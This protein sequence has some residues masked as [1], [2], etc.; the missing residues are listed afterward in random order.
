MNTVAQQ[1]KAALL[2][3]KKHLVKY[4]TYKSSN[5]ARFASFWENL[6]SINHHLDKT[7]AYDDYVIREES[8]TAT[9]DSRRSSNADPTLAGGGLAALESM[10]EENLG[11]LFATK[12][13]VSEIKTGVGS[14]ASTAQ[15]RASSTSSRQRRRRNRTASIGG[16]SRTN[17]V[18]F[19]GDD[20]FN[21]GSLRE[22]Y[23]EDD[24]L[25]D[26]EDEYE[27]EDSDSE[28]GT[29]FQSSNQR[30]L[31]LMI[32]KMKALGMYS[33]EKFKYTYGM[34]SPRS[35]KKA[36][37]AAALAAKGNVVEDVS[38][39]LFNV[40]DQGKYVD[41]N[42]SPLSRWLNTHPPEAAR[43]SALVIEGSEGHLEGQNTPR[44]SWQQRHL[45]PHPYLHAHGNARP[46]GSPSGSMSLQRPRT[47][48]EHPE[49]WALQAGGVVPLAM[50]FHNHVPN[51]QAS[52]EGENE[53]DDDEKVFQSLALARNP[54][55]VG[56]DEV[57]SPGSR[58]HSAGG[59]HPRR[60]LSSRRSSTREPLHDKDGD[61]SEETSPPG[62]ATFLT[63]LL[64]YVDLD[65]F[66]DF[67][68]E[69]SETRRRKLRHQLN[70][71][72]NPDVDEYNGQADLGDTEGTVNEV[73]EAVA[74]LHDLCLL[75]PHFRSNEPEH[76]DSSHLVKPSRYSTVMSIRSKALTMKNKTLRGKW[77]YDHEVTSLVTPKI[78]QKSTRAVVKVVHKGDHLQHKRYPQRARYNIH[79][80][81]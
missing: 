37:L 47:S 13:R 61:F 7:D 30:N 41:P 60:V 70:A 10:F 17:G 32:E 3:L 49:S 51:K 55:S 22:N 44:Q 2:R 54:L 33:E 6:L 19:E 18:R 1:R 80:Q 38:L 8:E 24:D 78:Y 14:R 26:D 76:H 53:E 50:G 40:H 52:L 66:A 81:Q 20:Y 79:Y 57:S 43:P 21:S 74:L 68:K 36:K 71:L 67:D 48:E 25:E 75:G 69:T 31:A 16:A 62:L 72:S 73:R 63:D 12:A 42:V 4:K 15:G 45:H 39:T 23:D 35:K 58:L 5:L 46:P 34:D 64:H 27:D 77:R 56:H 59:G 65:P 11:L 29:A 28:M 9:S